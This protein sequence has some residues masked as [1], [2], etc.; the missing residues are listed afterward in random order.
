MAFPP[1]PSRGLI[2][3]ILNVTPDSFSDGARHATPEAALE[4]AQR[5][6][7]DGVDVIDVGGESTRPG[8]EPVSA[9]NEMQRVLPAIRLL[10]QHLRIPISIDTT[11]A[12]VAEAALGAGATI[13]ND[14]SGLDADPRM[15]AVVARSG[16][17]VI[18]MHRRGNP[19]TMQ[20]LCT[21]DDLL[22]DVKRELGKRVRHALNAGIALERIAIDPG[23]GFA[24]TREQNWRLLENL[25]S[26]VTPADDGML[27]GRPVMIG[28]SRKSFLGG[29]VEERG[30]ATLDAEIRAWRQ[31]VRLIRTHDVRAL[32]AR[33]DV[34]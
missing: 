1:S 28:V 22:H 31:G 8:A 27:M 11:K 14:V 32:K 10:H 5:L 13:V 6:E 7:R 21:Y 33:L 25:D 15:A 2:F 19:A 23:I 26:F 34:L 17:E 20:G 12:D 24:K 16:A 4:H 29:A 9:A 18:L 3:G 30:A